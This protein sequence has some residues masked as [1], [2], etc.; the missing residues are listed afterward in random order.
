MD[1]WKRPKLAFGV[2]LFRWEAMGVW[3]VE[4]NK[5]LFV[6]L[7]LYEDIVLYPCHSV[8]VSFAMNTLAYA[9]ACDSWQSL[10]WQ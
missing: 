5:R 3:Q 8:A 7:L 2:P 1:D 6:P 9:A 4:Q 10:Q